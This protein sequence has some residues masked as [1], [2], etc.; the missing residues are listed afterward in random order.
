VIP[1]GLLDV[2]HAGD[3]AKQDLRVPEPA[4]FLLRVV[5][6]ESGEP[7]EGARV[8][9]WPERGEDEPRRFLER[10][11][12]GPSPGEFLLRTVPGRYGLA[13]EAPLRMPSPEGP[14]LL[15]ESGKRGEGTFRLRQAGQLRVRW[16]GFAAAGDGRRP[17]VSLIP[18]GGVREG[19]RTTSTIRGEETLFTGL[20][21]GRYRAEIRDDSGETLMDPWTVEVRGGET[22]EVDLDGKPP[23]AAP[24]SGLRGTITR[25]PAYGGGDYD[26]SLRGIGSS[27]GSVW[28]FFRVEDS[29][30]GRPSAFSAGPVPPGPYR[31]EIS[32]QWITRIEVPSGGAR[33]DL[34]VPE[35][36]ELGSPAS[37]AT[38]REDLPPGEGR[39]G[40]GDP[41]VRGPAR[42]MERLLGGVPKDHRGCPRVAGDH[43]VPPEL[44]H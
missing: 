43:E 31:L 4:E 40:P 38:G 3:G 10:P 19:W 14:G 7:V 8:S 22:A 44:L 9:L 36:A 1:G 30:P 37:R 34:T 29:A 42:V 24:E 5:A 17:R 16:S 35:P 6:E 25:H 28:K 11:V 21:P 32:P 20:A 13:I 23:P 15:L 41:E 2:L 18:E 27:N 33:V 39:F 12:E 26:A